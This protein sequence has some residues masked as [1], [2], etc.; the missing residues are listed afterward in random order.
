MSSNTENEQNSFLQ[1]EK[2]AVPE[3]ESGFLTREE[4]TQ[5]Q[6]APIC[7]QNVEYVQ[8]VINENENEQG[9]IEDE[10]TANFL[11]NNY[12]YDSV[13]EKL[14]ETDIDVIHPGDSVEGLEEGEELE[15]EGEDDQN[16]YLMN[17]DQQ[18]YEYFHEGNSSSIDVEA[19]SFYESQGHS[20]NVQN[21]QNLPGPSTQP[22][23]ISQQSIESN[24]FEYQEQSSSFGQMTTEQAIWHQQ[25]QQEQPEQLQNPIHL[26]V[27]NDQNRRFHI[28]NNQLKN[29]H[30]PLVDMS[31]LQAMQNMAATYPHNFTNPYAQGIAQQHEPQNLMSHQ[32]SFANQ[33]NQP[34]QPQ[35]QNP[36]SIKQEQIC[37][38]LPYH[39]PLPISIPQENPSLTKR[40]RPRNNNSRKFK[41]EEEKDNERK[42]RNR[43]AARKCR[44]KKIDTIER[45]EENKKKN[46]EALKRK[47]MEHAR[48]LEFKHL[49]LVMKVRVEQNP[50]YFNLNPF[51]GVNSMTSVQPQ[52]QMDSS[53]FFD[54][55]RSKFFSF[56]Q[57]RIQN[58]PE[59]M[60]INEVKDLIDDEAK[61]A[62]FYKEIL[63]D[64][65][66]GLNQMMMR[67]NE[68]IENYK[69]GE[70][71]NKI[72]E[73]LDRGSE[74]QYKSREFE[75]SK[76]FGDYLPTQMIKAESA[77]GK[78]KRKATSVVKSK[79]IKKDN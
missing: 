5:D 34:N 3:K 53:H 67:K 1:T 43:D 56:I 48:Y 42:S 52:W 24:T 27:Q 23:Q 41:T 61:K 40:G 45:L 19:P 70:F 65:I 54:I 76:F 64:L 58:N 77:S 74:V 36:H 17:M 50:D 37:P 4:S 49:L 30:Q 44:Q 20:Q 79:K 51:T 46:E 32:I 10:V 16:N 71:F 14:S 33:P 2:F 68:M 22:Q 63:G 78:N 13:S 31:N 47:K 9:E 25:Q 66:S 21:M 59:K 26:Q 28:I 29:D 62:D 69:P 11:N 8:Q 12:S 57:D 18:N 72:F 35:F 39:C 38:P 55:E 7:A 73:Y 6:I 75:R 15:L 60:P